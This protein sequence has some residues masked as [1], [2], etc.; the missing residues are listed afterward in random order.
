M[1][2][3]P[4]KRKSLLVHELAQ[5]FESIKELLLAILKAFLARQL[6]EK[7]KIHFLVSYLLEHIN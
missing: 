6:N 7:L 5:D 1:Y 2:R 3:S 4:V